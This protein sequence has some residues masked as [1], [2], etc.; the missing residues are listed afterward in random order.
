MIQQKL[1]SFAKPDGF[2][3]N[4]DLEL[5]GNIAH[6]DVVALFSDISEH[7]IVTL[8]DNI[9]NV[10]WLWKE[11][12]TTMGPAAYLLQLQAHYQRFR[13]CCSI[14][15]MTTSQAQQM[16]WLIYVLVLGVSLILNYFLLLIFISHRKKTMASMPL[17]KSD[18][19]RAYLCTFQ[20][21]VKDG[22]GEKYAQRKDAHWTIWNSH[23]NEFGIDPFLKP[24]NDPIPYL[25]V[26]VERYMSR[27]I[28]PKG[29]PITANYV[30]TYSVSLV[31]RY[32]RTL[33]LRIS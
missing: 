8:S 19:Y 20:Q 17:V 27:E 12:T 32:P 18:K 9:A 28:A 25:T 23:C 33:D 1:V 7:T 22:V 4:N 30:L 13:C 14:H 2:I 21:S 3:N 26:F 31:R 10:Y 6:H 16:I 11:S 5:C 15:C 29:K 24:Y